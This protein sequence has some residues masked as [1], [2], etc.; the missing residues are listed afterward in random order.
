MHELI[1]FGN[2]RPIN[3]QEYGKQSRALQ[4]LF[5]LSPAPDQMRY[6]L[7]NDQSDLGWYIVWPEIFVAANPSPPPVFI[8]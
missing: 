6:V 7:G 1:S 3:P 5:E 8:P 4:R 2:A